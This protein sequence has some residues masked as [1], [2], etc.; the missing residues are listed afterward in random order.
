MTG[1]CPSLPSPLARPWLAACSPLPLALGLVS[2]LRG[3]VRAPASLSPPT[4]FATAT[5]NLEINWEFRSVIEGGV[6]RNGGNV[7]EAPVTAQDQNPLS[8][9]QR[10]GTRFVR[11]A[12][13]RC[14]DH[15]LAEYFC[16]YNETGPHRGLDLEE[17]LPRPAGSIAGDGT[18]ICRR[19]LA[20]IIHE[21]E[22][23][24]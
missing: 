7:A 19:V 10:L 12:R 18:V 3:G 2:R 11:T 6:S 23:A 20:G 13:R 8:P 4:S 22:R 14:L 16:H 1:R 9:L 17:P 24:A 15:I 5:T 21:Y